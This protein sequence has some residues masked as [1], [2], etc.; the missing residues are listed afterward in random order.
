MK[1]VFKHMRGKASLMAQL[2]VIAVIFGVLAAAVISPNGIKNA[3]ASTQNYPPSTPVYAIPINFSGAYTAS[4]SNVAAI[5]MPYA[6]RLVGV[7]TIARV[8]SGT[9]ATQTLDV[10][11][12]A[13]CAAATSVLAAPVGLSTT[14]ATEATISTAAIADESMVCMDY[15][16]G[17]SG[18][19]NTD[20]TLLMTVVR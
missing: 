2:V 6:A 3:I 11:A 13:T 15:A 8:Y 17:V 14:A 18:V 9:G 16:L 10:R 1:A 5:K 20:M 12:G 7:S 4:T 19:S